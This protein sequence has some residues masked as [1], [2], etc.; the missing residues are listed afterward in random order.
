MR[1]RV[2]FALLLF[3]APAPAAPPL[4]TV[5]SPEADE[6]TRW[7]V[8]L[9]VK[10]HPLL[11][12]SM[13]AQLAKDVSAALAP[14]VAKFADVEVIDLAAVPDERKEPLWKAFEKD[15]WP[16]L[17]AQPFRELTGV[18]T[19]FLTI[20]FKAGTYRLEA[21][22][23]DGGTG[24]SSAL[25]RRRETRAAEQIGR[26]AGQ[27]LYPD[28]GPVGTIVGGTEGDSNGLVLKLR[29]SARGP[30]G[31]FVKPGDLF[32]V[33]MVT[34]TDPYE[35]RPR[36]RAKS[37]T[38]TAPPKPP[39]LV[40]TPREYTYLKAITP[41]NADGTLRVTVITRFET[42]L[43][44]TASGLVGVRALKLAG[45][46]APVR[47][48]VLGEDGKPHPRASLLT[49]MGT[50]GDYAVDPTQRDGFAYD[51]K[52]GTFVS[53]RPLQSVA[54]LVVGLSP[55]YSE[56]FPVPL[57]A[58]ETIVVR[59]PIDETKARKAEVEKATL[60]LRMRIAEAHESLTTLYAAAGRLVGERKNRDALDRVSAGIKTAEAVDVTLAAEAERVRKMPGAN[61]E[62]CDRQLKTFREW[63]DNLKKYETDLTAMAKLDPVRM[64]KELRVKD[65]VDRIKT[66]R[67]QGEI[68]EALDTFDELIE[69][70]KDDNQ[71]VEKEKLARDWA[72]KDEA[73]RAAREVLLV[74]WPKVQS[75]DEFVKQTPALAKAADVLMQKDD[76]M[77]VRKLMNAFT[78]ASAKLKAVVE[79]L[80]PTVDEDKV[81][82]EQVN[83][84][85][86]EL[87]T[88]EGKVRQWLE[89]KV[90]K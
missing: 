29:G 70:S 13:R 82:L 53:A 64:E 66:L 62:D 50:D 80:N 40:G 16:A 77:G 25:I 63:R 47:V 11:S 81:K 37:T 51:P 48:K 67:E 9:R 4:P 3:T 41:V 86:Q 88:L 14:G 19:H 49:V 65:L 87:I 55:T 83:N 54:C 69:L 7:R 6:W 17:A 35:S 59:F 20:E 74:A 34:K 36:T 76:R 61:L 75:I 90:K 32:A 52:D 31:E 42:G 89:A 23:H 10:P 12:E 56:R 30:M 1:L 22:Q 8:V 24:L 44:P 58:D 72:P 85:S 57:A 71:K 5:L 39:A 33:A 18:K 79:A 2:L 60:A 73:H 15:G 84:V 21:R 43:P 27:M 68:P 46:S 78:P 28:Y 45:V 26:L 38:P